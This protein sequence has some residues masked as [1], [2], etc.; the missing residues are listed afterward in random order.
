MYNNTEKVHT[1][2]N[3]RPAVSNNNNN[4]NNNNNK[5]RPGINEAGSC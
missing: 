2:Q 5:K 4:N 3:E 1:S